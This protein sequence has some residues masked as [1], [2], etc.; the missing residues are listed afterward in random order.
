MQ[1]WIADK[2]LACRRGLEELYRRDR[3]LT[4]TGIIHLVLFILFFS[5]MLMD[6]RTLLGL[7]VWI[8]PMKFAIS[9]SIYTL[10]LAFIMKYARNMRVQRF[11][12][13]GTSVALIIEILIISLQA[14]RGTKSHF[15]N[16]TLLEVSLFTIMGIMIIFTTVCAIAL[17]IH[18][19]RTKINL[20]PHLAF[21]LRLG[22]SI[23]LLGSVIGGYMS[24]GTQNTVGGSSGGKGLPFLNWSVEVG[25]LRVAH[26]FG[27]HALQLI[28]LLTYL[29]TMKIEDKR[30]KQRIALVVVCIYIVLVVGL[31]A[32]AILGMPFISY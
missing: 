18:L 1:R 10:S 20:P 23:S 31:F 29:L 14:G 19:I 9:I 11:V 6:S 32:Q 28:P 16:E 12:S 26:F 2:G 22:L 25:D 8:K 7:N 3:V 15:N 27:L 17:L 21:S 13:Y 30:T 24:S 5:F 4:I